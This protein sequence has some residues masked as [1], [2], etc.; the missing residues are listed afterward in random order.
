MARGR[1]E[2]SA[3]AGISLSLEML[4]GKTMSLSG[5]SSR[6]TTHNMH[7]HLHSICRC[8]RIRCISKKTRRYH[9]ST[10]IKTQVIADMQR[11]ARSYAT[12]TLR[13]DYFRKYY[14]IQTYSILSPAFIRF[15]EN[16]MCRSFS[17]ELLNNAECYVPSHALLA[18]RG[19]H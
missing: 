1:L 2:F 4:A 3:L 11:I 7:K 19:S 14:T 18:I 16:P 9:S 10:W 5:I 15:V 12:G 8:F 17:K 6:G 13:G